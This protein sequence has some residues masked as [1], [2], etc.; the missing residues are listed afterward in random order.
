MA[1]L[2][3][4][5]RIDKGVLLYRGVTWGPH[6]YYVSRTDIAR[7]HSTWEK[8]TYYEISMNASF[9]VL[10]RATSIAIVRETSDMFFVLEGF[11]DKEPAGP[12]KDMHEAMSYLIMTRVET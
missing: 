10:K 9:G 3:E 4:R 8:H 2:L 1:K 7:D 5:D 12:F 11:I 6:E